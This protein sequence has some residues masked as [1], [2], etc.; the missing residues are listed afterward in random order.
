MYQ[1][2]FC[3]K[4]CKLEYEYNRALGLATQYIIVNHK[5]VT[6]RGYC[7]CWGKCPNCLRMLGPVG[8][9]ALRQVS[10]RVSV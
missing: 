8:A 10:E 9:E 3:S 4:E 5:R 2:E 6:W 7:K 1:G